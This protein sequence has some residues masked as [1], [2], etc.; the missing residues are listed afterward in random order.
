MNVYRRVP[1]V[2][3]FFVIF[4]AG[5]PEPPSV[6]KPA[7][8]PFSITYPLMIVPLPEP[9]CA[10]C[11]GTSQPGPPTGT[12]WASTR[13]FAAFF[14]GLPS[15]S[16][17]PSPP[18]S[19]NKRREPC[20]RLG[21]AQRPSKPNIVIARTPRIGTAT[22]TVAHPGNMELPIMFLSPF[23]DARHEDSCRRKIGTAITVMRSSHGPHPGHRRGLEFP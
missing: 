6:Y 5:P 13:R 1:G 10:L 2:N 8:Y 21:L 4:C 17:G 19:Q 22:T 12:N 20:L 16:V 18:A 14:H 7:T 15:G 9:A 11:P 23:A 3:N